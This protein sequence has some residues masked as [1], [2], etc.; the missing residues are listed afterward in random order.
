M[1]KGKMVKGMRKA[2]SFLRILRSSLYY[3]ASFFRSSPPSSLLSLLRRRNQRGA[4]VVAAPFII[5]GLHGELL[6]FVFSFHPFILSGFESVAGLNG[7]INVHFLAA[8][9]R[10][11][12][13]VMSGL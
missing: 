9:S 7:N 5:S 11:L 3:L 1:M 6:Y 13:V 2:A 4:S 8:L 12:C 10:S